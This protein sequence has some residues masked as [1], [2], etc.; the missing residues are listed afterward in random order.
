MWQKKKKL[1]ITKDIFQPHKDILRTDL[2]SSYQIL[3]D[4]NSSAQVQRGKKFKPYKLQYSQGWRR[5]T[6]ITPSTCTK[7]VILTKMKVI[8]H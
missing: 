4:Y 5:L 1:I 2:G 7:N 6:I 8:Q 3:Y